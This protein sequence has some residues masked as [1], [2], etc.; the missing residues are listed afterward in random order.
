MQDDRR[1]AGIRLLCDDEPAVFVGGEPDPAAAEQAGALGGELR[2]EGLERTE[3]TLDLPL[4]R[5]GGCVCLARGAELGEVEIVVEDLS[6]VVEDGAVGGADDLFQVHPFIRTAR[7]GGLE[8]VDVGLQVL[9]V[10]ESQRGGADDGL[11]GVRG[12]GEFDEVHIG[13]FN[14]CYFRKYK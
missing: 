8:V 5:A 6:G 4:Q 9:A 12:V 7:Q 13:R 10:V 2:L 14:V 1:V 3:L 11:Q